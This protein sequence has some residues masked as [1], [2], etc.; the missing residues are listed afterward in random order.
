MRGARSDQQGGVA[1]GL[2][3]GAKEDR[4]A[5]GRGFERGMEA[6]HM[7]STSHKGDIG[8][9]VEVGEDPDAVDEHEV[10][11]GRVGV[12][13]TGVADARRARPAFDGGQM[14]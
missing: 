1:A 5:E 10:G 12:V 4:D 13:E 14:V 6:G 3:A 9:G 7:E 8:G 2:V 11:R